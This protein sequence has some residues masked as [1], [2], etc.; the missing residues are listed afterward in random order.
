MG[1][2]YEA[3]ESNPIL[4]SDISFLQIGFICSAS[5]TT[6]AVECV[7][8]TNNVNIIIKF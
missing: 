4:I 2:S 1:V 8:K 3:N 6:Y 7:N 5:E